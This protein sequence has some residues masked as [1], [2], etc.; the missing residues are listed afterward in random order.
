MR[1]SDAKSRQKIRPIGIEHMQWQVVGEEDLK[2]GVMVA[3]VL[4]TPLP[5]LGSVNDMLKADAKEVRGVRNGH[6]KSVEGKDTSRK[7]HNNDAKAGVNAKIFHISCDYS[8]DRDLPRFIDKVGNDMSKST[9]S[10]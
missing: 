1:E 9:Q 3:D 4:A 8:Y 2:S 7:H 5:L 6:K 10:D